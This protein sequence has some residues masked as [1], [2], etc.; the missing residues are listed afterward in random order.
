M[1][2]AAAT[3]KALS[4]E[5]RRAADEIGQLLAKVR[6]GGWEGPS[7]D[8]YV[9]GHQA[10]LSWLQ[11]TAETSATNSSQLAEV[12]AAYT[13]ALADMP[14]LAELALNHATHAALVGTNFFGINTIPIAVNEADYVRMWVQ[15]A[16]TMGVYDGIAGGVQVVAPCS[17]A[18]PSILSAAPAGAETFTAIAQLQAADSRAAL[19][20]S[21]SAMQPLLEDILNILLPGS[22]D[23][24]KELA[25]LDL[26]QLLTLLFTNPAAAS[27]LLAPL[28]AAAFGLG[29]WVA[30]S[31]TLWILQ[32]GSVLMILGPTLAI[33]LAI[34]LA[35]PQ[36][37]AAMIQ[38]LW[39][40]PSTS[41][42]LV[43]R[44]GGV[45]SVFVPSPNTILTPS[46]AVAPTTPAT[47]PT[48]G[49]PAPASPSGPVGPWYA[50]AGGAGPQPPRAPT[51]NEGTESQLS[52]EASAT[53]A[54][55]TSREVAVVARRRRRKRQADTAEEHMHVHEFPDEPAQRTRLPAQ[56]VAAATGQ[57]AEPRSRHRAVISVDSG[58]ITR[59]GASPR[60]YVDL[61]SEGPAEHMLAQPLMPGTWPPD[62]LP[63]I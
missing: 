10:Y 51:L 11:E 47:P 43:A 45:D 56:P 37:L 30:T 15:A 32:I 4:I 5:Y 57:I 22:A 26:G 61:G 59:E 39:P 63:A 17:S 6:A 38:T 54:A 44:T 52:Q 3:W 8:L 46:S 20:D 62:D 12:A 14:T 42:A 55:Q 31:V 1:L 28:L 21:Q 53:V 16:T 40:H 33:P 36:R 35:D 27:N 23:V 19:D 60:G 58:V 9:A 2:A 34:V 13:A 50:V 25:K 18:V 48:T 29:Q 7:A 49:T 41:T 24:L